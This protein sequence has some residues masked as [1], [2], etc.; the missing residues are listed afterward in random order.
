M[1]MYIILLYSFM[2]V[3]NFYHLFSLFLSA[4]EGCIVYL[5]QNKYIS[6]VLFSFKSLSINMCQIVCYL[7]K[8][9]KPSYSDYLLSL[10]S[11]YIVIIGVL[12]LFLC[13]SHGAL[14]YMTEND[15]R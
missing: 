2:L 5:I 12:F 9:P 10:F 7:Q 11:E 8:L 13:C 4:I 15:N 14:S 3:S 1:Y 6:D